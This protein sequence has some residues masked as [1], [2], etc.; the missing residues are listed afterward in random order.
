[1]SFLKDLA[2]ATGV[3]SILGIKSGQQEAAEKAAKVLEQ[4][5]KSSAGDITA[6]GQTA[7][8][9]LQPFQQVGQQGI[10][11]AGFLGNPQAQFESIQSNPL[12]QMGLNNLNTQTNQ[13]AASRGRLSA[14]DTLQ[15]LTQNATLAASPLIDRQRQDI[16]NLLG[17]GGNVAGQQA[18]IERGTAADVADLLTGG[19]SAKASGIIGAE[20]AKSAAV[21]QLLDVAGMFAGVPPGTLSG[22]SPSSQPTFNNAPTGPVF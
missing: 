4:Q 8:G 21:G 14:G 1:M 5:A 7:Q 13:S 12:F 15:Q 6:A 2:S 20:N 18:N 19:A 17:I 11:L 22:F 10:D 9:F 3:G 16:L